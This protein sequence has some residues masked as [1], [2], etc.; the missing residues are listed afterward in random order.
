MT[1]KIM[2]FGWLLKISIAFDI[3]ILQLAHTFRAVELPHFAAQLR[4]HVTVAATARYFAL[5]WAKYVSAIL[6][7]HNFDIKNNQNY[8]KPPKCHHFENHLVLT[9]KMEIGSNFLQYWL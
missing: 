6:E 8:Q 7:L 2:T 5:V 1:F 3:E 4:W 9:I